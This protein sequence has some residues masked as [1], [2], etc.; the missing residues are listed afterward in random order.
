MALI[1]ITDQLRE[2]IDIR[3]IT[4]GIYIDL[5]RTTSPNFMLLS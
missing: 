2:K 4:M 3:N 1:E 5:Q